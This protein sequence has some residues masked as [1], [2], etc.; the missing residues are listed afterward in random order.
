MPAID[1]PRT[2]LVGLAGRAVALWRSFRRRSIYVQLRVALL[3]GYAAVVLATVAWV[4]SSGVGHNDLG[5][6]FLVLEGDP[7]VGPY[8]IVANESGEH[9]RDVVFEIDEGYRIERPLVAAG[10]KL[11]LFVKDFHKSVLRRRRG[12]E[13]PLAVPAPVDLPVH[14]LR[15]VA[16]GGS[17]FFP[18]DLGSPSGMGAPRESGVE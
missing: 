17:A 4:A 11:T 12:K 3:A 13:I 1:P 10:E 2:V 5:A 9:W 8:F 18:V 6:R 14:G 7:I 15:V 16:R